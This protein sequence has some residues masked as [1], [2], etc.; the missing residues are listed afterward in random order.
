MHTFRVSIFLGIAP[1]MSFRTHHSTSKMDSSGFSIFQ[2]VGLLYQEFDLITAKVPKNPFAA[3]AY[4][5]SQLDAAGGDLT[6]AEA[7][8]SATD[9]NLRM[10]LAWELLSRSERLKTRKIDYDVYENYWPSREFLTRSWSAHRG[11]R[12]EAALRCSV[13]A[14]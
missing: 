9:W 4:F 12:V 10:D 5:Y 1:G 7:L 8:L 13:Q 6:V 3:K 14:A 11:K 2:R